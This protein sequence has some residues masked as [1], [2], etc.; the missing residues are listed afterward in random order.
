MFWSFKALKLINCGYSQ[1]NFVRFKSY[2]TFH[3]LIISK[4]REKLKI[5]PGIH[6]R[7]ST[8]HSF[9]QGL[10]RFFC[11]NLQQKWSLLDAI[12]SLEMT[13]V[14]VS[15]RCHQ[16]MSVIISKMFQKTAI[17]RCDSISRIGLCQC[18]SQM[19]SVYVR[20]CVSQ[21]SSVF[22]AFLKFEGSKY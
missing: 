5:W 20:Q 15:V 14:S 3:W 18:V 17:I 13:H 9:Y 12:A 10:L 22:V 19:S 21:M 4:F 1:T 2:P 16:F 11:W 8:F 6:P 7:N